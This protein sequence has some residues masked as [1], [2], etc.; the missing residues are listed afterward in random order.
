MKEFVVTHGQTGADFCNVFDAVNALY[1]LTDNIAP[2]IF[3]RDAKEQQEIK[4]AVKLF[5]HFERDGF[6]VETLQHYLTRTHGGKTRGPQAK[7]ETA[8]EKAVKKYLHTRFIQM[9]DSTADPHIIFLNDIAAACGYSMEDQENKA[10][11]QH[12]AEKEF[13]RQTNS[14]DVLSVETMRLDNGDLFYMVLFPRTYYVPHSY[15]Q[16]PQKV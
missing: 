10:A 3:T 5:G 8:A 2:D 14:G 6:T 11:V 15:R 13:D 16:K 7:A 4:E 12:Y 9:Q 1:L